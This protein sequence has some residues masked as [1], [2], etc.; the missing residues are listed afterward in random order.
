MVSLLENIHE[1]SVLLLLLCSFFYY[2]HLKKLKRER[3]LSSFEITMFI[4][5]QLAYLLWAGSYL[6][7]FLDNH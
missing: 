2:R 6:L 1:A 7:L 3:K 5:T 4:L